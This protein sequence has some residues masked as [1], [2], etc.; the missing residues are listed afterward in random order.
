[1][2]SPT[3]ATFTELLDVG[4]PT[5]EHPKR[6]QRGQGCQS[7]LRQV[8]PSY[9][10]LEFSTGGCQERWSANYVPG[11]WTQLVR[12]QN[13][14]QVVER[15]PALMEAITSGRQVSFDEIHAALGPYIEDADV[16]IFCDCVA[17]DTK[18]QTDRGWETVYS[19][20]EPL[21][22]GN[23][24]QRYIVDGATHMGTPP[25]FKGRQSVYE[26][27]F[28]NGLTVSATRDHRFLVYT[29]RW[30]TKG[31][32]VEERTWRCLSD[33][34]VGSRVVVAD[35]PWKIA[36]PDQDFWDGWFIGCL[37]GDGSIFKN[38]RPDL[39]LYKHDA[40]EIAS[41]L[42]K[43]GTVRDVTPMRTRDGVRIV[44][45]NRAME[46]IERFSYRN[47][48][49]VE[50]TNEQQLQ[51]YV[52]GL[53]ATDGNVAARD[54]SISGGMGYL[55]QLAEYLIAFGRPFFGLAL[56]REAGVETNLGVATKDMWVMHIGSPNLR[57][58]TLALPAQKQTKLSEI[59]AV[60]SN[61]KAPTTRVKGIR[62]RG[63]HDVYDISIP[64]IERF[65]ANGV[66]AHNCSDFLY[67][68][69][70]YNNTQGGTLY[71]GFEDGRAPQWHWDRGMGYAR[72]C[73]H[74]Y[75]V[76]HRFLG[77]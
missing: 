22:P 1:M 64:G 4:S 9:G 52:S 39:Q 68:G 47:K 44:F 20:A 55:Q 61:R 31:R 6:I 21:I 57:R 15:S 76:F 37:M 54:V 60:R 32:D 10:I 63:Q 46:L 8:W 74:L 12:F 34:E 56:S 16:Q 49:S 75:S 28:G 70:R 17:G 36:P 50:I 66:I 41:L 5:Q 65:V 19:L 7:S 58:M 69:A 29:K 26:I 38:D 27:S 25:F 51:G 48:E 24:T 14:D 59:C 43:S 40:L 2:I 11:V 30:T 71:P 33:L 3:A 73:K 42:R 45:N 72:I 62:Y 23:Y 18:V 77:A 13:W 35:N 67:S 53:V